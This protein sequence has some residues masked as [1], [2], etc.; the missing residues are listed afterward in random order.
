[1]SVTGR[2]RTVGLALATVTV[3]VGPAMTARAQD[4]TDQPAAA[5]NL[6][7]L[8]ARADLATDAARAVVDT[9]DAPADAID[10]QP[11]I[12]SAAN[13]VA[14]LPPADWDVTALAATLPDPDAAFRLLRDS[15][16]FD[17]YRGLLRGARG[18]WAPGPATRSTGPR[19][20]R[21][22]STNKARPRASPSAPSIR[23]PPPSSS[24]DPWWH[25]WHRSPRHSTR[26]S[27]PRSRRPSTRARAAT[28]RSWRRPSAIGSPGS[29]QMRPRLRSPT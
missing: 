13:A 26:P 21:R 6:F 2:V 1:M 11:V 8:P 17:A 3:M 25:L 29:H 12:D 16:G 19:S 22:C 10:L 15:I 28:T 14:E 5:A 9:P 27:M 24:R 20:S 7:V 23:T 4:G 18:R